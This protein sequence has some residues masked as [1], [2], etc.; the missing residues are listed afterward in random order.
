MEAQIIVSSLDIELMNVA[1]DVKIA[2]LERAANTEKDP[3]I[4]QLR[5]KSIAQYMGL[6]AKLNS[7]ELFNEKNGSQQKK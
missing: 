4:K 2:S 6:K 1:I 7:K 5:K 3:E